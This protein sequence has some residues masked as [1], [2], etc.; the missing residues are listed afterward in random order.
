MKK[1]LHIGFVLVMGMGFSFSSKSACLGGQYGSYYIKNVT[2]ASP[3]GQVTDSFNQLVCIDF[4]LMKGTLLTAEKFLINSIF[5]P[6]ALLRF[7][8]YGFDYQE[9]TRRIDES[10]DHIV[11]VNNETDTK[12]FFDA[13]LA[14]KTKK[15]IPAAAKRCASGFTCYKST[16]RASAISSKTSALCINEA[17]ACTKGSYVQITDTNA[18]TLLSP[19]YLKCDKAGKKSAPRLLVEA[20][21]LK[22][23]HMNP[24]GQSQKKT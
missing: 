7:Q 3:N 12:L 9:I 5:L 18:C 15:E 20:N 6:R 16:G 21:A 4:Q 13:Y 24:E 8:D 11:P 10:G 17:G 19:H 1:A 2:G 14:S 23:A 22:R